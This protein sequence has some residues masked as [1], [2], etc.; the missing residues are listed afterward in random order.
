MVRPLLFLAGTMSKVVVAIFVISFATQAHAEPT[1]ELT[2]R[3]QLVSDTIVNLGYDVGGG[4]EF[5]R[6]SNSLSIDVIGSAVPVCFGGC[7]IGWSLGATL[8]ARH[9]VSE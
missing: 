6:G 1:E 9:Q 8:A 2:V 7:A 5:S 4:V 3:P